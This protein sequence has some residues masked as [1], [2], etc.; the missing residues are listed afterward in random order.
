MSFSTQG[1]WGP[2]LESP[3]SSLAPSSVNVAVKVVR[4]LM[5]Q[6]LPQVNT[7][8]LQSGTRSADPDVGDPSASFHAP[9]T[10]FVS[11]L[12]LLDPSLAN[13]PIV[14]PKVVRNT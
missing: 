4:L 2:V 6:P 12:P 5:P 9:F 8:S 11:H 14:H 1:L 13:K 7:E 10:T 3:P